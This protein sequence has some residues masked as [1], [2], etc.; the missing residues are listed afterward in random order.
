MFSILLLVAGCAPTAGTIET[1]GINPDDSASSDTGEVVEPDPEPDYSVWKG[2]RLFVTD[3]CEEPALEEGHELT[4]ENW[5]SYDEVH[6][7]CPNCDHIYYVAVSPEEVCGYPITE[8][9]YRG[10]DFV[11][12]G[13]AIFYNFNSWGQAEVIDPDAEFDGWTLKY[14]YSYGDELDMYG[15][16][17]FP[18]KE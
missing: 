6:D 14:A 2:E 12:D 16:V 4:A 13:G 8:V 15:T 9:R 17:S 5:D 1:D 7:T 18:E 3:D 11:E 10:V